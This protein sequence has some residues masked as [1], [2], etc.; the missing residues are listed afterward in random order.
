M[1]RPLMRLRI[2]LLTLI[3]SIGVCYGQGQ[4]LTRDECRRFMRDS[5]NRTIY[6]GP[7]GA[8]TCD[9]PEPLR[10]YYDL[11]DDLVAKE[12]YLASPQG[13]Q[14]K[15]EEKED[16]P[17]EMTEAPNE[18][19]GAIIGQLFARFQMAQRNEDRIATVIRLRRPGESEIIF[20]M[21][22]GEWER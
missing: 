11:R 18:P 13:S 10:P 15:K 1:E 8:L 2:V 4:E 12:R 14:C 3:I 16:T 21:T 20:A 19:H 22:T 6:V 9:S 7:K 5:A 17:F